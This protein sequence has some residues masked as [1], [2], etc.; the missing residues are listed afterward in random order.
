RELG[1]STPGSRHAATLSIRDAAV[2]LKLRDA[3]A[4]QREQL[5]KLRDEE[6]ARSRHTLEIMGEMRHDLQR[7]T[8]AESIAEIINKLAANDPKIRRGLDIYR[9][10]E[11]GDSWKQLV[12][13]YGHPRQVLDGWQ[14]KAF[15][16]LADRLG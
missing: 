3:D 4:E 11:S 12:A 13:K 14:K 10:R 6:Q 7:P 9:A 5:A 2:S 1:S 15:R 8:A 16:A